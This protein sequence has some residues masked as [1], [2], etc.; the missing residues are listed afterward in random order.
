[1][2]EIARIVLK[3]DGYIWGDYVWAKI[4]N[5][6]STT[7]KCR[8]VSK[9]LFDTIAIPH[10]FLVDLNEKYK[11]VS[12]KTNSVSVIKDDRKI[13]FDVFIHAATDELRFID[14]TDF[15]C[16]LMDYTRDGMFL[17]SIPEIITYEVSPFETVL[18]H[19][20]EKKL[21]PVRVAKSLE[22]V[23]GMIHEGWSNPSI[24]VHSTEQCSV[25]HETSDDLC[26]A[27]RCGHVYHVK[28]LKPW[29]EK[30]PTCPL[31][32]ESV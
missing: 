5:E 29:L 2:D 20:K 4:R 24:F 19:I 3:H 16:N 31:C 28:C 18:G 12:M 6:T 13:T 32:R 25:C 23:N 1:M 11:I 9:T 30:N 17:R 26:F 22:S 27:S 7:L 21:V 8:F 14:E 15:T 10:H